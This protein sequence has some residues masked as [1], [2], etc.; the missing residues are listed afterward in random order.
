MVTRHTSH[1][2]DVTL[3]TRAVCHLAIGSIYFVENV[4][5]NDKSIHFMEGILG[6]NFLPKWIFSKPDIIPSKRSVHTGNIMIMF[7]LNFSI[8]FIGQLLTEC[9]N[10]VQQK[11]WLKSKYSFINDFRLFIP[12]FHLSIIKSFYLLGYDD[13]L[14]L[15]IRLAVTFSLILFRA[16][17]SNRVRN[18]PHWK[19][20]KMNVYIFMN[21]IRKECI[22]KYP[23]IKIT[24]VWWI[25]II[26]FLVFLPLPLK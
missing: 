4:G 16:V 7:L 10:K 22:Q 14:S 15:K 19:V 26:F 24:L 18:R 12:V 6:Q 9:T 17:W 5:E 25:L 1:K 2:M 3:V 20:E 23:A 11:Y 13:F 8:S 21:G